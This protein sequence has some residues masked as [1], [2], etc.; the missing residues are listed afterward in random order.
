MDL[1]LI[2]DLL[3]RLIESATLCC[4]AGIII[5]FGIYSEALGSAGARQK[6]HGELRRLAL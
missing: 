6:S 1:L 4:A 2:N 5:L 3:N